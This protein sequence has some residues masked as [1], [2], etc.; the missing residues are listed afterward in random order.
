MM[1]EEFVVPL[2]QR[3]ARRL[4]GKRDERNCQRY[5]HLGELFAYL[6]GEGGDASFTPGSVL[7]EFKGERDLANRLTRFF[8]K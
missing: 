1:V 8:R 4:R 2:N 6:V 5:F 7:R 3:E